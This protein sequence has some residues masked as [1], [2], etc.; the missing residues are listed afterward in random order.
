MKKLRRQAHIS[1][2]N[3]S[4]F[5]FATRTPLASRWHTGWVYTA[6]PMLTRNL[7]YSK[8]STASWAQPRFPPIAVWPLFC[9]LA[10]KTR[11]CPAFKLLKT[12]AST[13]SAQH[14]SLG[15][16][17]SQDNTLAFPALAHHS[18]LDG[19]VANTHGKS[20]MLLLVKQTLGF[21]VC[22]LLSVG[23]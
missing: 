19:K 15:H 7:T 16:G 23:K 14:C 3:R 11:A 21:M 4:L 18:L 22:C 9:D 12:L 2:L 17:K 5:S 8:F 1:I 20:N 6:H 13:S 10:H